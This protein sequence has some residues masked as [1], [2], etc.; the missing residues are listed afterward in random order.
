MV[1]SPPRRPGPGARRV[2]YG[3]AAALAGGFW[4]LVNVDP[5]WRALPFLTED[6]TQVLNLVNLSLWATFVANMVYLVY[7]PPWFKAL[8]D[9]LT[10]GIGLAVLVRLWQVFPF[11]FTSSFDWSVPVRVFL[12]LGIAGG[13]IGIAV[14]VVTLFRSGRRTGRSGLA[15]R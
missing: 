2:G 9:V 15:Q 5:G 14:S 6:T 12:A 4:Y 11:A 13:V 3:I 1:N 8:G 10:T 7:D